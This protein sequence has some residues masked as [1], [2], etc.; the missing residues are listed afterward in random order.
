MTANGRPKLV[1]TPVDQAD[2]AK[3]DSIKGQLKLFAQLQVPHE[4]EQELEQ[5]SCSRDQDVVDV[6]TDEYDCV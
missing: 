3:P 4:V 5:L 1:L 2:A 6:V